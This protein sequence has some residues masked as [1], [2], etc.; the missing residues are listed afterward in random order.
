MENFYINDL[1]QVIDDENTE[2]GV[3]KRILW[4]EENYTYCFII[5]ISFQKALPEIIYINDLYTKLGNNKIIK[6]N[7]DPLFKN[8]DLESTSEKNAARIDRAMEVIKL[9]AKEDNEPD[10]Y[11]KNRRRKLVVKAVTELNINEVTVY[12]YLRRYW[13]GGKRNTALLS[14]YDVCGMKGKEK[15]ITNAKRGR[16]NKDIHTKGINIDEKIKII[17]KISIKKWYNDPKQIML[18]KV[19]QLMLEKY[20]SVNGDL[21]P[22]GRYPSMGQFRYW[23]YNLKDEVNERKK[24]FSDKYYNLNNRPLLS[25]TS[26]GVLGPG[27]RFEIDASYSKVYL[28]SRLDRSHGIGKAVVYLIVDVFSRMITGLYVGVENPSWV[29]ASMALANMVE[30]KVAFCK[31]YEIDITE[32]KWPCKYV[33]STILAD[34]GEFKWNTPEDLV[35]NLNITIENTASGRPD[36]KPN[37]ERGFGIIR[38]HFEFLLDG[39]VT[40]K[41]RERGEKDHRTEAAIDIFQFTQIVIKIV[42]YMNNHRWIDSYSPSKEMIEDGIR[43]IPIELWNYGIENLS[44]KLMSVQEDIFKINLLPKKIVTIRREGVR[45]SGLYY[46]FENQKYNDLILMAG[47]SGSKKI[48]IRYDKRDLSYI[49]VYDHETRTIERAGLL[50]KSK[51]YE[52]MSYDEVRETIYNYRLQRSK[53]KHE[54]IQA[55]IYLNRGIQN[56]MEEAKDMSEHAVKSQNKNLK[57]SNMKEHRKEE[58]L[59]IRDEEKFIFLN[60]ENENTQNIQKSKI[61]VIEEYYSSDDIGEILNE[62]MGE[63]E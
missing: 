58:K 23:Y 56:I 60:Q 7:N 49:Y 59:K 13:Q 17:F 30:D 50:G 16:P 44:G 11:C 31:R 27:S 20:F 9:I 45:F 35:E 61:D 37:V 40:K 1:F 14:H 2:N 5:D 28:V 18:S 42:L 34:K 46:Y 12:K 29:A 6:V 22:E 24:R 8:V 52:G 33:P 62:I 10:I 51:K 26:S 38:S 3:I 54:Q 39:V 32:G 15:R 41:I 25:D 19:Y 21:F 57:V 55:N 36:M 43:P 63:E 53:Y 47:I 48:K 4:I